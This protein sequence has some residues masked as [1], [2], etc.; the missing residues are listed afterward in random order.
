MARR[1]LG[2]LLVVLQFED[3]IT[4]PETRIGVPPEP[5]AK[6]LLQDPVFGRLSSTW[7]NI[8]TS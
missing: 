6:Q 7:N 4:T 5:V 1:P 2:P 8:E 3:M